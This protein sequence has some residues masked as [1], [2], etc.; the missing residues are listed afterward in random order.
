M[1]TAPSDRPCGETESV[2][3]S[4]KSASL[5]L[6]GKEGSS[7][8]RD[9]KNDNFLAYVPVSKLGWAVIYRRPATEALAAALRLSQ[10]NFSTRLYLLLIVFNDR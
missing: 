8:F 10:R 3:L 1:A 2:C 7:R 5:A 9:S 6:A 4:Q